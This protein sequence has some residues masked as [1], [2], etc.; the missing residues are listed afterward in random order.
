MGEEG[1]GEVLVAA[2]AVDA[3]FGCLGDVG[4]VGEVVA[5]EVGELAGFDGRPQQLDRVEFGGT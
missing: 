4:D 2:D 5:G 3:A 1:S